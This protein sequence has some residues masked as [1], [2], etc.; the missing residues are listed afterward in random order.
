MEINPSKT[1]VF[2]YVSLR[3][4]SMDQLA[5]NALGSAIDHYT[6]GDY[7]TAIKEFQRSIAMSPYSENIIDTYNYLAN[8]Y[9]KTGDSRGAENA[10]KTAI[11]IDPQREDMHTNLANLYYSEDKFVQAEESYRNAVRV[12]PSSTTYYSLAHCCLGIGKLDE[13]ESTFKKVIRMEPDSENGY[14]GLGMTYAKK[15]EYDKAIEQFEKALSINPTSDDTRIELGYALADSGRTEEANA[16]HE[17]LKESDESL[18]SLL[19]VY[20]YEAEKPKFASAN[21]GNFNWDLSMRTS[22]T[23]LNNYLK[24]PEETKYFTVKFKFSKEMD[25][26]SVQD[27]QNWKIDKAEGYGPS[28]YNFGLKQNAN[29]ID[30]PEQPTSVLYDPITY[31][32]S[33]TFAIQQND[34]ADGVLDPG[35]IEFS[36]SG[37]DRFGLEMDE[38]YDSF[39]GFNKFA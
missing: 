19:Y 9:L 3:H 29:D 24:E 7:K 31:T 16:Q 14:Y 21:Q 23:A 32:A 18:A 27:V 13:A 22:I 11:R 6:A 39:S 5:Q 26:T 8:A 33:V 28:A 37:T 4:S 15:E 30:V 2:D 1:N 20:M 17:I 35:H 10:Y 34:Q 38:K 36:F 12:Y 25:V